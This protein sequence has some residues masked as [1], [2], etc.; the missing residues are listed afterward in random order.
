MSANKLFSQG[1]AYLLLTKYNGALTNFNNLLEKEPNNNLALRLRGETYLRLE[2]YNEALTD[3]NKLL[4]KEPNNTFAL[5]LRGETYLRLEEY[6]EALTDFNELLEKEP[7]NT[8]ALRLRGE[9]YRKLEK[10]NEALT[11]FN[12]LLK[13]E[14][15]NTFALRLRGETYQKLKMHHKALIDFNNLLKKEPNNPFALRLR[16]ETY[17]KLKAHNIALMDFN[18]LLGKEPNNIVAL[19]LRGETYLRLEKYNIALMDFNELLEKEPNNTFALRLRGETY[20]KLKMH[21]EALIDFNKSLIQPNNAFALRLR[22]ETYLRLEKY[23]EAL[24]DFNELLEK[25]PNNTFA[26]RLRGETYQKLKMH[27]EALIDFNKSLIQPN[28][29]RNLDLHK[30]IIDKYN[31]ILELEPNNALALRSRGEVYLLLE[32]YNNALKDFNKLLEKEPNNT[33]ALRLRGETYQKLKM[34]HEALI[35]FNKSLIQPNNARNLDLHKEIID[36]YNEILELEPNNALALR[37]RGEVYL[38]L[39]KYDNALKDFNNSLEKEPN[40]ALTLKL[41]GETYIKLEKYNEA[42]TD[43]NKLLEKEP[44]DT[45][46]LKFRGRINKKLNKYKESLDDFYK[47]LKIM[48]ISKINS[49]NISIL[50]LIIET[51]RSENQSMT[52]TKAQKQQTESRMVKGITTESSELINWIPYSQFKDIKYIAEGGFGVVSSAIWIKDR[53][54]EIKVALKNLHNSKDMTDDFLKE[55]ISHGITSSNDFILQCYGITKDHNTN[56][57]MLVMEFAEDGSLHQDLLKNFDEIAWK[58]KLERLY[59]IATG[60]EQIHNN[61]LIHR[62]LHSGNIL[63]GVNGILG[64][65]R[66]ADLGLCR[67]IDISTNHVYGIIPYVAPEIFEDSSYSQ[68]SD[69]YSF[70]MLMWEFTSGHRPFFNRPHNS[71]LLCNIRG[72]LRPEITDDTPEV[73]SNL[74]LKCWNSNPVNRPNIKEIKEQ[75]YKWCWEKESQDRFIQAEKIRKDFVKKKSLEKSEG[76]YNTYN[77]HP[78]AIYKSR[79]LFSMLIVN[80]ILGSIRIADLGLCR[81]IDISTNHVY[82]IIPYVAPEIFEDSSYSQASD[83]YSF[84]MLMW[85]FTSGHR[86][87]FNRPH[88]SKLLCNIRGGLRPEITDDTPE[89]FSNLMLKCW[90]SNPVNRPNI[91]EIKEQFYKWCW[92]K[93]SQDRF[94]QAEKIRKDFVKKKSLEKSEGIYNTYNYHPEA[95]YKSRPL[96]SMLIDYK[97]PVSEVKDYNSIQE[98]FEIDFEI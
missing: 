10:Y 60:L 16:G 37:S 33:F 1:K 96:F 22:G 72:G 65:I 12:N 88:N 47:I 40:N 32:K 80:G 82:G 54:N 76:I 73:F 86:P 26:L 53:I 5:R 36:K 41:R 30:E 51:K 4:E 74:M 43:F 38:L 17:Q 81:N 6:N 25:E 50:N 15:N 92:E 28:N 93:E 57:I 35:D 61:N 45:L 97:E 77:Y 85:E 70:G 87:F 49:D 19:R 59:C 98:N 9:T 90:N 91:K 63:M 18:K 39:E 79:P 75:F 89:V 83:V 42:L 27:H 69:V 71:K 14:P 48:K 20:Q 66:I 13:K 11:D 94:I 58:T 2:K 68:A 46:A 24:T 8:F 78:E 44:N 64:S 7:N 67:N 34:H 21:H 23:N 52:Y 3:L 31:E 84:G 29:A 95:I 56:S 55:V 62:D